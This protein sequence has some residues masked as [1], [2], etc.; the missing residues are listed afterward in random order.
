MIVNAPLNGEP[1]GA[2]LFYENFRRETKREE[3]AMRIV[4]DLDDTI[5][6][7]YNRDFAN[8]V[9]VMETVEKIRKLKGDGCEI[10]IYSA[11]G[12]NSC[13]G[14]LALIE[15]R[16]RE[17]IEDWLEKH[18]V[19]YDRLIFG[20][21]LGDLYVDDKG[22]SLAEFLRGE[23]GMLKGNSGS[24][25]YRA[26]NSVIKKCR[27]ARQQAD[28]YAKAQEIGIKTPK[29]FSVVLDTISL[30]YLNG[31]AG[32]KKKLGKAELGQIV[33]QIMLMSLYRAA[34]PFDAHGYISFTKKR[35]ALAGWEC[36]FEKLL[37]YLKEN[38][39][40]FR[41]NSTFSH[42]DLSL[43]NTIFS[44]NGL[45]LIDP[46]ARTEYSTFLN[47]F[48]KLRFSLDGGEQLLHGGERPNNYDARLSELSEIL[49]EN[50]L[51]G[52]TKAMEAV[53]WIRMLGYFERD[54][55]RK[56]IWR[57][58]KELEAEI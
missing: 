8:A 4:F 15:K 52:I 36:C 9:P 39:D 6:V 13:K 25:V 5:S 11:R 37:A 20:K 30:E 3:A 35:L 55:D 26:G 10:Y 21:P 48:A 47:D 12:Q 43:S 27:D 23:Y 17:Q 32:N 22:I 50:N 1:H 33:S 49:T 16:N 41:K 14:D 40:V 44:E 18:N 28:W 54:E 24:G 34:T 58:A 51:S 53:H 7:H 56:T 29:V 2:V 19:P 42:G 46:S 31:E 38:A 45:Y 57:K